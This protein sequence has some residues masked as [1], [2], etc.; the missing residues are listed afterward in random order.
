MRDSKYDKWINENISGSVT[1]RC[2]EISQTMQSVFP[3]LIL[4]RGHYHCMI[5]G[6]RQHW[7]LTTPN[8]EIIDP[9]ADQFPTKGG[10]VYIPWIEGDLEPT[11]KCLEC[12][13]YC[14]DGN[15]TCSETCS[16][17]FRYSLL[18]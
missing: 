4:I 18:G 16:F 5:W 12:G 9:T 17:Y 13:E 3:E 10:G 7:W 14:Y 11:G 1:G 6:E 8:G 2:K 15:P